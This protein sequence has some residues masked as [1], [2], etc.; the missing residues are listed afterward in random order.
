MGWME[1]LV[2]AIFIA[3][4]ALTLLMNRRRAAS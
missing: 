4:S 3:L 1:A 2:L